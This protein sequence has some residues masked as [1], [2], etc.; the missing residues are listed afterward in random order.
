MSS[1]FEE[2]AKLP[3]V[4]QFLRFNLVGIMTVVLGTL[5]FFVLVQL[6]VSYTIA[7]VADYGAGS[8]FSYL[9]NKRYTFKVE[10]ENETKPILLTVLTYAITFG[11]N[12]A[13]LALAVE[14]FELH[15]FAS[16]VVILTFLA[17]L[18]FLLFKFVVFKA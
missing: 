4:G 2:V 7:L 14:V 3:V 6:D 18:N 12:L 15:V 17:L 5:V 8:C 10:I 9:M 16:Q 11:L 1:I 13:L